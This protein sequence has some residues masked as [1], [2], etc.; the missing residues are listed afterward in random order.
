MKEA[1]ISVL[2]A[3]DQGEESA[4]KDFEKLVSQVAN[5]EV[6]GMVFVDNGSSTEKLTTGTGNSHMVRR[7][8]LWGAGAGFLIGL[9]PLVASTIMAAA[10]GGMLAKAS[11]LRIERG[12]APR[13][14]FAKRRQGD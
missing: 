1:P 9:V 11:E 3:G 14:R 5:G 8:A 4:K 13:L 6:K 12:T 10:L 2:V 7:G